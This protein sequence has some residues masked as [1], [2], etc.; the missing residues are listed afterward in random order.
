MSEE[1]LRNPEIFWTGF[2]M[3]VNDVHSKLA[4]RTE[5]YSE[6]FSCQQDPRAPEFQ[7]VANFNPT[8]LDPWDDGRLNLELKNNSRRVRIRWLKFTVFDA[9]GNLKFV[10]NTAPWY[11]FDL[12]A[13]GKKG[14]NF[15]VDEPEED[16]A[17]DQ[18]D[19]EQ[20]EEVSWKIMGEVEYGDPAFV[21]VDTLIDEGD[22][23]SV[24]LKQVNFDVAIQED[25][26]QLLETETNADVTF[27]V[28]D[29][30]IKAHKMILSARSTYFAGMFRSEMKENLSGEVRVPDAKPAAFRA[31]LHFLYAGSLPK[32]IDDIV[33][34]LYTLADKHGLEVLKR[35]CTSGICRSLGPANVVDV[36]LLA[37]RLNC[38]VLMSQARRVFAANIRAVEQLQENGEKLKKEPDFLLKLLFRYVRI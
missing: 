29:E 11:E 25:F 21:S 24:R 31:L 15:V 34:D 20:W 18:Y 30:K 19:D 26:L 36:L 12:L 32:N 1:E 23:D 38:E 33:I 10:Q 14:L 17:Y 4:S 13:H 35:R 2:V 6:K 9:N 5:I 16:E 8:D 7:L 37:E 22:V 3:V 27:L 28:A